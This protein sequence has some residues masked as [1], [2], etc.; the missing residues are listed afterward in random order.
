[1]LQGLRGLYAGFYPAVLGSTV[2]WGLYFFL[3]EPNFLFPEMR[4]YEWCVGNQ[5]DGLFMSVCFTL[6]NDLILYFVHKPKRFVI[7]AAMIEQNKGVQ[8]ARRRSWV[9]VFILLLRQK[10]E[11]WWV[12][13]TIFFC[14]IKFRCILLVSHKK[15]LY[16][17]LWWPAFF[18]LIWYTIPICT[19]MLN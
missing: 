11:L 5:P 16:A 8:K 13:T 12:Q 9:L 14:F 15:V 19:C 10:Q 6:L 3:Y 18:P 7:F 4:V 1:M 2:S 17:L